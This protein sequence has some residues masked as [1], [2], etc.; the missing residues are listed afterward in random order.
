MTQKSEL[1]WNTIEN[2]V[3]SESFTTP[4]KA[5]PFDIYSKLYPVNVILDS[6]SELK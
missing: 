4:T 3:M 1:T 2:V 5:I 6:Y